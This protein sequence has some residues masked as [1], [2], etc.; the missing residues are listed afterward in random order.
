MVWSYSQKHLPKIS[1]DSWQEFTQVLAFRLYS[2]HTPKCIDRAIVYGLGKSDLGLLIGAATV[3]ETA[4]ERD[5][6]FSP[7]SI[8]QR[9][10]VLQLG[11]EFPALDSMMIQTRDMQYGGAKHA[12]T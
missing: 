11:G 10:I 5:Y 7:H 2:V 8:S 1:S 9:H 4:Q 3:P 12:F 6:A